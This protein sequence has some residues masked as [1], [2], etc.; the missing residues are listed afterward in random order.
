MACHNGMQLRTAILG[1]VAYIILDGNTIWVPGVTVASGMPGIG[2]RS[3]PSGNAISLAMLGPWDNVAPSAVNPNTIAATVNATSIF[4]QWQGAVDNANGVGVALYAIE[5][6][7]GMWF[8]SY[9]ASFSDPTV[10]PGTTYTYGII[11]QRPA[12]ET[13]AHFVCALRAGWRRLH[14]PSRFLRAHA[15]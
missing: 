10:Q 3:M 13:A 7:D 14:A 5:R 8:Y 1:T 11:T 2:G 4:A 12:R 9:D 15:R 6:N